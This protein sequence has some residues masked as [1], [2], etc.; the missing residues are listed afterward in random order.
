MIRPTAALMRSAIFLHR[1]MGVA[2][3]AIFMVWFASGIVMMYWGFPNISPRERLQHLPVLN[4]DSVKISPAEAFQILG[5]KQPPSQVR[6]SS[7][8]GRPV[9]RFQYG[10]DEALVY[11]DNGMEQIELPQE[12][13]RRIALTW[14]GNTQAANPKE[15]EVTEPDQWT[16]QAS[17]NSLRP[18]WK[19]SFPDGLQLYVSSV[20]GEVIQASTTSSRFW[21]YLGAIPHW[22]YFTPLRIHQK[23]W[24][25]TVVWSSGI[26]TVSSLLGLV[27]GLW[28]YSPKKRY[29]HA[30]QPSAVPYRGQKRLHTILGLLF[31]VLASTW[32][33]SG[34]LSMDPFPSSTG[35]PA[36]GRGKEKNRGF[37][38]K[39]LARIPKALRDDRVELASFSAKHPQEALR[40]AA[41]F[42]A[43][44]LILTSITGEPMYVA[45]SD[46]GESLFIPMTG[47][48]FR[49]MD[50]RRVIE[51]MQRAAAPTQLDVRQLTQYDA[52]YLDRHREK[53]LPVLLVTE[54]ASDSARYY[55]DPKTAQV[56]G[57]YSSARWMS[58]WLYHGLHSF[59]FP[60][61]YNYRPLW[62]IVVI[63]LMLGGASLCVTSI[64]L[65]WQVLLRQARR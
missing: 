10:R 34:M 8:D 57:S 15:E 63:A 5:N 60:W 54:K 29:V 47:A 13:V 35:G 27:V 41:N 2:L 38:D 9:Y 32:A 14:A 51:A 49:D 21:A 52:Y 3:S 59:D 40:S 33:F 22:L 31:G 4:P 56:V 39:G 64:I 24:Y 11:A 7:F 20:T 48:A 18:F 53:P 37:S 12:M 42:G 1:W 61:L 46:R 30:G 26:G 65:T 6:L 17:L 45:S 19:Y 62:D 28:M 25:N 55:V 58:R 50:T 43:K 23:E 16:V 36:S 44:E